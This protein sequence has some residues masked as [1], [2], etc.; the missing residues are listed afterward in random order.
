MVHRSWRPAPIV[1][2]PALVVAACLAVA[3]TPVGRGASSGA[4]SVSGGSIAVMRL[5][6]ERDIEPMVAPEISSGPPVL[7][8]VRVRANVAW[9]VS[10]Q[11]SDAGGPVL[12]QPVTSPAGAAAAAATGGPT[13]STVLLIRA[14]GRDDLS[15][16]TFSITGVDGA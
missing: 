10:V 2:I 14:G 3:S 16:I 4:L 12:L 11:S 6:V 15:G 8:A 7:G 1:A 13:A 9:R 5:V